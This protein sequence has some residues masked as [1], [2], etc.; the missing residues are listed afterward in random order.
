MFFQQIAAL[1]E[2]LDVQVRIMKKGEDLTVSIVPADATAIKPLTLK[3]TAAELDANFLEAI[4][5]PMAAASITEQVAAYKKDLEQELAEKKAAAATEVEKA[6]ATE[7]A[8]PEKAPAK[9]RQSAKQK[10][11]NAKEG[12]V[13]AEVPE[14]KVVLPAEAEE[15]ANNTSKKEAYAPVDSTPAEEPAETE[16][17]TIQEENLPPEEAVA[18]TLSEAT[19]LIVET[20]PETSPV[21]EQKAEAQKTANQERIDRFYSKHSAPEEAP[22]ETEEP[23]LIAPVEFTEIQETAEAALVPSEEDDFFAPPPMLVPLFD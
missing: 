18:A 3:G 5:A 19:G 15:T 23:A 13:K 10:A 22:A 9:K 6:D 4:S 14:V 2:N 21:E 7:T 1:A 17:A 11:D 8:K 20:N 12:E 16:A